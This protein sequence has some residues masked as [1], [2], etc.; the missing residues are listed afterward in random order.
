MPEVGVDLQRLPGLDQRVKLWQPGAPAAGPVDSV[1][2]MAR[3]ELS[4]AAPDP[5]VDMAQFEVIIG[6][7]V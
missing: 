3:F 6:G 4:A 7:L 1:V 2:E 5:P